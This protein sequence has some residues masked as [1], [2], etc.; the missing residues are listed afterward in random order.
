M[1]SDRAIVAEAA[2]G[3]SKVG[4]VCSHSGS[5]TGHGCSNGCNLVPVDAAVA[6]RRLQL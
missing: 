4:A 1:C 5:G 2:A 6:Q 3:A